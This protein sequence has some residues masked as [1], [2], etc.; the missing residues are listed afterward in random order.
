MCNSRISRLSYSNIKQLSSRRGLTTLKAHMRWV[1]RI[2]YKC[3]QHKT[4]SE[5]AFKSC[6]CSLYRYK[7]KELIDDFT[8]KK[9]RK[10]NCRYS[11]KKKLDKL[12]C[13]YCRNYVQFLNN[14]AAVSRQHWCSQSS[15]DLTVA[16]APPC[17]HYVILFARSQTPALWQHPNFDFPVA[18]TG[19]SFQLLPLLFYWCWR[20]S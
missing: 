5:A 1:G 15:A 10:R 7:Q 11:Q 9:D 6:D 13:T 17:L 14:R 18:E 16:P 20:R 12:N 3:L 4:V 8:N 2:Y 19:S